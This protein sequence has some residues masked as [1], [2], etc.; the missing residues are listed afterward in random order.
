MKYI[1]SKKNNLLLHIVTDFQDFNRE[2]NE[3]IDPHEFLQ[4]ALVRCNEGRN[5]K[6]HAHIWKETP[7]TR[8]KTQECWIVLRG[9]IKVTLYDVDDTLIDSLLIS[10]GGALF[11]LHGGHTF[12]VLEDHTCIIEIKTG[13]YEGQLKDKRLYENA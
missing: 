5:F 6:P 7:H 10:E 2:R 4:A 13:P 11:T 9:L 3:V 1:H 8:N 12:E